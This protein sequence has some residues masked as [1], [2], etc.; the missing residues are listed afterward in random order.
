MVD[1]DLAERC[2]RDV[3]ELAEIGMKHNNP[4]SLIVPDRHIRH[5]RQITTAP[6]R[7]AVRPVCLFE[8]CYDN[9]RGYRLLRSAYVEAEINVESRLGKFDKDEIRDMTDRFKNTHIIGA[10]IMFHKFFCF[11][12]GKEPKYYVDANLARHIDE[13]VS[14]LSGNAVHEAGSIGADAA[15]IIPNDVYIKGEVLGHP[16][17]MPFTEQDL[18]FRYYAKA[19][20]SFYGKR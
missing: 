17:Q 11:I 6:E 15:V 14:K 5:S 3:E 20:A 12:A 4:S 19:Y 1:Q 13:L 8:R 9:S 16:H 7:S 2:K 10:Y 18:M